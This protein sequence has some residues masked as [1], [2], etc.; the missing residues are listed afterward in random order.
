MIS[1]SMPAGPRVSVRWWLV[2]A[3][4]LGG[5]LAVDQAL[6]ATFQQVIVLGLA[7][8]LGSA[9]LGL[10]RGAQ[11]ILGPVGLILAAFQ[12]FILPRIAGSLSTLTSRQAVITSIAAGGFTLVGAAVLWLLS[13]WLLP[14]LF[15]E[16]LDVPPMLLVAVGVAMTIRA[17]S[18]GPM[19]QLKALQRG[20]PIATARLVTGLLS[21]PVVL[22]SA[23]A[24]GLVAAAWAQSLPALAFVVLLY[25]ALTGRSPRTD[26]V[27]VGWAGGRE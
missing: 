3:R 1:K 4:S 10:L 26:E 17:V 24:L 21:L 11:I 16:S 2:E 19:L 12:A 5:F 23:I 15:G 27:Q 25:V 14:L 18:I 20:A 7:A 9:D 22:G 8:I 6:S 13:P